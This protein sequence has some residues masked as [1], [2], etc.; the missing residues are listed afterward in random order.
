MI[1]IDYFRGNGYHCSCC[2]SGHSGT[3]EC[4]TEEEAIRKITEIKM[5]QE[6]DPNGNDEG[7]ISIEGIYRAEEIKLDFDPVYLEELMSKH[8]KEKEDKEKKEKEANLRNKKME[9]E[10]LKKELGE[11][12]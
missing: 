6:I 4:E 1:R 12:T 10:A 11:S 9:L 5:A 7:D 8:Q 2:R 3:I